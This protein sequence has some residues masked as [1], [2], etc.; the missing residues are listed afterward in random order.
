MFLLCFYN[1]SVTAGFKDT[2]RS[3]EFCFRQQPGGMR[4]DSRFHGVFVS[5]GGTCLLEYLLLQ[6]TG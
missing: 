1:I 6:W 4:S 2:I 5:Q 3:D